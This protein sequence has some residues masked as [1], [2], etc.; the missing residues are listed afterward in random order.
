MDR[1]AKKAVITSGILHGTLL[2]VLLVGPAFLPSEKPVDIKP[3]TFIPLITT[4][5][6]VSGGGDPSVQPIIPQTPTTPTPTPAPSPAP[7]PQRREEPPKREEPKPQPPKKDPKPAPKQEDSGWK[8]RSASD[9]K[10][11]L[12]RATRTE[13][14][15]NTTPRNNDAAKALANAANTISKNASA[16]VQIQAFHGPGGGGLPYGPFKDALVGAYMRAWSISSDLA[17]LGSTVVVSVTVRRDG[18]VVSS[19]I[20]RR[21]GNAELDGSVQ[22]ALDRVTKVGPFPE[23]WKETQKTF[24]LEFDPK[25]KPMMG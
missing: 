16:P 15:K 21:S 2:L 25:L 11:V 23:S 6:D 19:K 7:S 8:A 14:P 13:T 22:D 18:T 12:N 20:Q 3:L 4:D 9:I 1:L 5:R 24:W 17:K 10:P